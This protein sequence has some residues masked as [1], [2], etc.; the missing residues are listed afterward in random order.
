MFVFNVLKL[1]KV[2]TILTWARP[3]QGGHHHV[4]MKTND[5]VINKMK[6]V[7]FEYDDYNSTLLQCNNLQV[8]AFY[9]SWS[10]DRVSPLD[11]TGGQCKIDGLTIG[12]LHLWAE[13]ERQCE[14]FIVTDERENDLFVWW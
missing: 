14:R 2:G 10:R 3:G 5:Y 1:A 12:R 6:C 9:Y 13:Q 7:G 4:N 8:V 11:H